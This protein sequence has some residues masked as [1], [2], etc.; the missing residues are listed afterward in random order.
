MNERPTLDTEGLVLIDN[1][2]WLKPG[3]LNPRIKS[4][5]F[6][7]KKKKKKELEFKKMK[8][9]EKKMQNKPL[10]L[11]KQVSGMV[12]SCFRKARWGIFSKGSNLP[13][14]KHEKPGLLS[15]S[16]KEFTSNSTISLDEEEAE[17]P[18][19]PDP[20]CV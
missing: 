1:V 11:L 13:F 10:I 15:E 8:K 18:L 14:Q 16:G 2:Y 19:F 5:F 9:N 20:N 4:L 7:K 3:N 6:D 12:L 17:A